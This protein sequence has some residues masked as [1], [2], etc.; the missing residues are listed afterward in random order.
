[1]QA[2]PRVRSGRRQRGGRRA[3]SIP[4][5]SRIR[6]RLARTTRTGPVTRRR[7]GS[8]RRARRPTVSWTWEETF[9]SGWQTG[10]T[11]RKNI[12]SCAGAMRSNH[13]G[14]VPWGVPLRVRP[15]LQVPQFRVSLCPGSSFSLILFPFTFT[16]E[17]GRKILEEGAPHSPA[18]SLA[19]PQGRGSLVCLT[20]Q[21]E[22]ATSGAR[23]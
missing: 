17:A 16:G 8:I 19:L 6:T 21:H 7:S 13:A 22:T 12:R 2:H 1:M 11:K 18:A 14:Y 5:A 9:G 15:R 4:G 23:L 10:M 20:P 3:G